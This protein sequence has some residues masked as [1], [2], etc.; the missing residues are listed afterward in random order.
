MLDLRTRRRIS[1]PAVLTIT[2]CFGKALVSLFH[3][4]NFE[5]C[6]HEAIPAHMRTKLLTEGKSKD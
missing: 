3:L 1:I 2:S 5:L 6:F 4:G